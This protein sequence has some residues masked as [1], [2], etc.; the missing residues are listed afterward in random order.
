MLNN[1]ISKWVSKRPSDSS[2]SGHCLVAAMSFYFYF[3]NALT[4][5]LTSDSW[6]AAYGIHSFIA[7]FYY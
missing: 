7:S 4:N 6:T 3:L 1:N 2:E 5:L